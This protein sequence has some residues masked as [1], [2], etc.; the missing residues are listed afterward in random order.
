MNK[1]R[2]SYVVFLLKIL[3]FF[4]GRLQFPDSFDIASEG[5]ADIFFFFLLA[6]TYEGRIVYLLYFENFSECVRSNAVYTMHVI[7]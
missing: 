7:L 4:R 2:Y 1:V 5:E 6:F 3:F